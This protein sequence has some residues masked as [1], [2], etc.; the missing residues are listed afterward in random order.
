[1]PRKDVHIA[2][3]RGINV[4]KAKRVAMADLR[5]LVE[6]LGYRDVKTLLNS[7][8]VVYKASRVTPEQSA[9]KIEKALLAEI[10]IT[11]KIIGLHASEVEE[12]IE[13][14]PIPAGVE[15]P[16]SYM[17]VVMRDEAIVAKIRPLTN[18][19]WEG[20]QVAIGKRAAYVWARAGLLESKAFEAIARAG[21][22][23]ITVRNW[24]TVEK[25]AAAARAIGG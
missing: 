10:G 18:L 23:G 16:S 11:S 13:E 2:L 14:N 20:D 7:G 8:N 24:A 12:I 5:R 19:G 15:T 9:M 17:V 1:M 22:D 6:N 25:I 3:L 4:G 21:G